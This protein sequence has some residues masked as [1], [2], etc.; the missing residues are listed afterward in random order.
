MN[1]KIKTFEDA[2]AAQNLDP[3]TLPDVSAIP[4]NY[5]TSTIAAY[6]LMIVAEA[7]NEGWKPDYSNWNQYKYEPWFEWSSSA[8]G[9]VSGD[10][11]LW[12]ARTAVGPRLVFKDAE[13]AKYAGQQFIDLYNEWMKI[14]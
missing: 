10:Y 12:F 4:E 7:L 14:P 13:T 6:K 8:G 3:N 11:V 1:Q 5:Q 9:F 2:C